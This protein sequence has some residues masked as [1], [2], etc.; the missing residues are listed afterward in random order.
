MISPDYWV[1]QVRQSVR[2]LD[3]V[4]FLYSAGVG[5]FLELGPIAALSVMVGQC[6]T[7][8]H[9]TLAVPALRARGSETAAVM[10]FAARAYVHGVGLDWAAVFGAGCKRVELPTYAFERQRY[11][12]GSSAGVGDLGA[13]GLAAMVHPF[14]GAGVSLGGGQGWLFTGRLSVETHPWL[15]DHRVLTWCWF[16]ARRWWRWRWPPVWPPVSRGWRSWC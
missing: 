10:E 3:G 14:L 13:V 15:A 4:R 11:W 5:R 1:R 2:F 9:D 7:G 6:L 16:R 12:L 8:A